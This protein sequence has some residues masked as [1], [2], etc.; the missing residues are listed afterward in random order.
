MVFHSSSCWTPVTVSTNGSTA[1]SEHGGKTVTEDIEGM[2]KWS[3]EN[4]FSFNCKH[5]WSGFCKIKNKKIKHCQQYISFTFMLLKCVPYNGLYV[6][7]IK[8]TL[9]KMKNKGPFSYNN[10]W[11]HNV[12][13]LKNN[14]CCTY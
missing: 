9:K 13:T 10:L 5:E 1:A 12:K 3:S 14:K 4:T 7:C 2:L 8:E 6:L 11:F